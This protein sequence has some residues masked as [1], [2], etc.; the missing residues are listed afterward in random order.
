MERAS[1]ENILLLLQ[2]QSLK[3]SMLGDLKPILPS[4]CLEVKLP[5]VQTTQSSQKTVKNGRYSLIQVWVWENSVDYIP[6]RSLY[7]HLR[8][9]TSLF[10]LLFI[11]YFVLVCCCLFACFLFRRRLI[12]SFQAWGKYF[13]FCGSLLKGEDILCQTLSHPT[14]LLM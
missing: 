3:F 11:F 9:L 6:H 4:H 8:K 10:F 13:V 2:N 14:S 12:E 1:A 7:P 5:T